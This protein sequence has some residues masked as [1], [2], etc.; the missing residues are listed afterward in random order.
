MLI[1]IPYVCRGITKP[2]LLPWWRIWVQKGVS[3]QLVFIVSQDGIPYA[4]IWIKRP[5][6]QLG[7]N[8]LRIK[9][10]VFARRYHTLKSFFFR[11][12]N[13]INLSR[14][15]LSKSVVSVPEIGCRCGKFNTA[16]RYNKLAF[17]QVMNA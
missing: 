14:N 1:L 3:Q 10:F 8:S 9:S 16:V 17:Q 11:R 13:T 12:G 2:D 6:C 4:A 15:R 7:G 5:Y